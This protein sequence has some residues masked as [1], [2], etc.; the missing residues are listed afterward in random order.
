MEIQLGFAHGEEEL[1]PLPLEALATFVLE[2][3]GLPART[4]VS[5]TFVSDEDMC[6][7]NGKFR[8]INEV[9]DVLSFGCDEPVPSGEGASEDYEEALVLGDVV[10]APDVA[11]RQTLE[12]GTSFEEEISYLLVHGLLHLCGLDHEEECE[13]LDMERLEEEILGSWSKRR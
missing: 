9:T 7:L 5:V 4:E 12:F 11:A 3:R 13:A 8:G 6:A 1:L 2:H 10:I